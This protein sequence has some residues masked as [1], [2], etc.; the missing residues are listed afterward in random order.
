MDITIGPDDLL[1]AVRALVDESWGY[2]SAIVGIDRPAPEP[3][4]GQPQEEGSIEVL[5][6][7]EYGAAVVNLRVMLPYS[8]A[9]VP[10]ISG[11][12][13]TALLYEWELEEMLGVV[14]IGLPMKGHLILADDWPEG[15]YPLRKSFTGFN[16]AAHTEGA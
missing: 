4:D 3:A 9:V 6:I 13:P 2:L 14:V 10:T 1:S 8:K 5:Y 12:L 15:V 7:F 16:G 11:M